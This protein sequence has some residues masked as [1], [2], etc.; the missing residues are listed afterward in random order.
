MDFALIASPPVQ[1]AREGGHVARGFSREGGQVYGGTTS[2]GHAHLYAFLGRP[3]AMASDAMITCMVSVCHRDAYV[4]LDSGS[5]YSYVPL[6]FVPYLDMPRGSLDISVH[7]STTISD[8]I[9]KDH[10]YWSCLVTN[11]FY[12]ARLDILLLKM[13][14]FDVIL[15]MYWLFPYHVILDYHVKTVT[16][17]MPGLPRLEWR[18]SLGHTLSR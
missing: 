14:D 10:V 2:G 8:S 5:T 12:E 6:Y 15:G 9:M 16:L 4:L 7:V 11:G 18:V 1:T 17:A 13:V 3:E